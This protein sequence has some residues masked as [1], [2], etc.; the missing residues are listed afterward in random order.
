MEQTFKVFLI[1]STPQEKYE[2]KRFP[3]QMSYNL[4]H[5]EDKENGTLVQKSYKIVNHWPKTFDFQLIM[6]CGEHKHP[7]CPQYNFIRTVTQ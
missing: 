7:V 1:L 4:W 2:K 5:L 3:L 6:P